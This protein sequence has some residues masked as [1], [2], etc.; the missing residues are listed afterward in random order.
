[1]N[2]HDAFRTILISVLTGIPISLSIFSA[3]IEVNNLEPLLYSLP[4]TELR[5]SLL[6]L[7]MMI[8]FVIICYEILSK[9][10][11]K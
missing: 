2:I 7:V 3:H 11:F 5:Y 9:N 4:L 10:M 1:M 8:T 6:L